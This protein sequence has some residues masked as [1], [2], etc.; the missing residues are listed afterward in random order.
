MI[1]INRGISVDRNADVD[2][3]IAP[4]IGDSQRF[5]EFKHRSVPLFRRYRRYVFAV[6]WSIAFVLCRLHEAE[7]H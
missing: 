7:H 2:E 6:G 1:H 4:R 3:M 5:G